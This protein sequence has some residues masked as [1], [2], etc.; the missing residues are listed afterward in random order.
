MN[1]RIREYVSFRTEPDFFEV[2]DAALEAVHGEIK[3]E[4]VATEAITITLDYDLM[5]QA[6]K[7]LAE[8][9]WT[10][11]EAFILY[12][13]WCIVCPDA[14]DEWVCRSTHNKVRLTPWSESW[15]QDFAKEKARILEVMKE[16]HHN[17]SVRH[18]GSTS[19]EG[20][21]AK[22]IID[23][24]ISPDEGT[25][26]KD[27]ACDLQ[28]I[29]YKD[30][31]ECGRP[32]RLFLTRG[33]RPGDTFY[34][35][36]CHEDNQVVKNQLFFQKTENENLTVP[37]N[38]IRIKKALAG[39]FPNDREMYRELKGLYI[40]AVLSAYRQAQNDNP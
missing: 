39:I 28:K 30:F 34:V 29:G 11:E 2:P 9:G 36:L 17:G 26:L 4:K 7:K 16:S 27:I 35:H 31:G 14:L 33:D 3:R 6:E 12:L 13:Y 24:L 23:I 20:M 25:E 22:P 32:G 38:Y 1:E 5:Q 15:S 18:V 37:N 40:E 19:I 21:I 10:M 8:I